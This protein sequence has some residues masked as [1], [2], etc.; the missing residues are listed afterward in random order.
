MDYI[1]KHQINY[2]HETTQ[3]VD[4]EEVD[5]ETAAKISQAETEAIAAMEQK[6]QSDTDNN[7]ASSQF[8]LPDVLPKQPTPAAILSMLN[9]SVTS[10]YNKP[11]QSAAPQTN[12]TTKRLVKQIKKLQ[13]KVE[14]LSATASANAATIATVAESTTSIHNQL[15]EA[16]LKYIQQH[17]LLNQQQS[18]NSSP[19]S[20]SHIRFKVQKPDQS[21]VTTGTK[22]RKADGGTDSSPTGSKPI[23]FRR[24][25]DASKL[26]N[27]PAYPRDPVTGNPILPL[28]LGP[29]TLEA[30]GEIRPGKAYHNERYIFP[31]GYKATRLFNS[32]VH[33]ENRCAYICTITADPVRDIPIFTV[34]AS[35][36]PSEPIIAESASGAWLRIV[37]AAALIRNKKHSNAV[38]GPDMFGLG[39]PTIA[40]CIQDLPGVEH[41]TQ[42]R[43]QNFVI[44]GK[45]AGSRGGVAQG[46]SEATSGT[47]NDDGDEMMGDEDDGEMGDEEEEDVS[48]NDASA[49]NMTVATDLT[50]QPNMVSQQEPS[51]EELEEED[52]D[53]LMDE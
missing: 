3:G 52:V 27:V 40:K 4:E 6:R 29:M 12:P 18:A 42:Y 36:N 31:V 21:L 44:V 34:I 20:F 53:E 26:R 50:N 14:T 17:Q 15:H 13:S 10:I 8:Q 24:V 49:S 25:Y 7:E 2:A 1:K 30:V 32:M 35:D 45:V 43:K 19:I 23:K 41:C 5:N 16:H 38:A 47:R 9:K 11:L 22:R 51:E 46:G 33:P 39:N 37:K 48:E 28:S